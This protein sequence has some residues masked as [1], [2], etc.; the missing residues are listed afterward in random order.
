MGGRFFRVWTSESADGS[1]DAGG[2]PQVKQG[3]R[4]ARPEKVAAVQEITARFQDS[5]AALLTEYRGLTVAEIAE[6]RNA[7]RGAGAD[8]KVLKNTLVKIA[9]REVGYEDLAESLTGPTAIAFIRGDVVEAAKALDDAV[10]K[11][12]VLVVKGGALKGGKAISA[13][14]A[15]ALAKMESR[16][17]LLTKIAMMMN[18]PAQLTVNVLAALLR[19]L[20]SML[21]QVVGKKE[22]GEL[23]GGAAPE[24][25]APAP[26]EAEAPAPA[27]AEAPAP[28]EAEAPAPAEAEAAAP[29]AEA[30]APEA[31]AEAPEAEAEAPEAEA[32]APEAEAEAPEAEDV[33]QPSPEGDTPEAQAE[34]QQEDQTDGSEDQQESKEE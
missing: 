25:E 13:D 4:M 34:S 28:A 14:D 30:A 29:E 17:V 20:G 33:G 9:I 27:E 22:S 1:K 3:E 18:Q 6:V 32:E 11:F 12:P 8:Y 16:E 23:P 19:D 24:A 10:K 31:E 2:R 15:K 26:A 7:L 21:V 5:D